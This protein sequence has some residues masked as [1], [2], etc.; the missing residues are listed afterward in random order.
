M[1]ALFSVSQDD[2]RRLARQYAAERA[3]SSPEAESFEAYCIERVP[4]ALQKDLH[5]EVE[6]FLDQ[7]ETDRA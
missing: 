4:S 7:F 5:D 6:Y 2:L 3:L 1:D